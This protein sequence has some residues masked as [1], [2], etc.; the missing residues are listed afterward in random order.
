[1]LLLVVFIEVNW[2]ANLTIL[3]EIRKYATSDALG[4]EDLGCDRATLE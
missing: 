3:S 2:L 1:M 4:V